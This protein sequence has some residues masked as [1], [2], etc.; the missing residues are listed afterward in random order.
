MDDGFFRHISTLPE[1]QVSLVPDADEEELVFTATKDG[2]T[3]ETDSSVL[4]EIRDLLKV[5]VSRGEG[6]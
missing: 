2:V 1:G 6:T 3:V 5:L 4:R